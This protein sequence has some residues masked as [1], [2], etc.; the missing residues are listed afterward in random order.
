MQWQ[1]FLQSYSLVRPVVCA[2]AVLRSLV[3]PVVCAIAVLCSLVT[4]VVCAIAV[5]C[6]L[7]T[8]VVCAIAVICS[9]VKP[10][11]CAVAVSCSLVTPVVCAMAVPYSL[12]PPVLCAMAVFPWV[13]FLCYTGDV[14]SVLP[15]VLSPF[16]TN[17]VFPCSCNGDECANSCSSCYHVIIA[18][19]CTEQVFPG[20]GSLVTTVVCLM[21]VFPWF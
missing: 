15:R 20:S 21:P 8:P 3:T 6:S 18:R 19:E 9:L 13:L 5:L 17:N 4:P 1:Y 16:Y 11:V 12:G 14:C 2:I 7:V 10:V